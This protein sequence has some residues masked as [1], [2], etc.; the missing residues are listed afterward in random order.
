MGTT[1]LIRLGN[2]FAKR[3]VWAKCEFVSR[4]GSFKIRGAEHLLDH[5][6]KTTSCRE[7]VLP[8]MGNTALGA[9]TAGRQRG[10]RV[11]SVV[12]PNI[13]RAKEEKLGALGVELVKVSGGGSALIEHAEQLAPQRSA[14]FM[15]PHLDRNWTDGYQEI[16]AEI[17][18]E[19]PQCRSL[20]FPVGGGGLLMGLTGYLAKHANG[21]RLYG[22][23]PYNYPTYASFTHARST[24]IADGLILE[25]P[26]AAVQ[27]RINEM[28]VRIVVVD[29]DA[30]RTGLRGLY[31][32]QG[33]VVEP[34]SAVTVAFI[35]EHEELPEPICAI[36]T[37][38]NITEEDFARLIV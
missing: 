27:E 2:L 28:G 21:A 1:P 6:S 24:T 20:V 37:G 19:L 17:L 31:E 3:E 18:Q 8:S 38:R 4:S 16:A 9:A 29:E 32:K 23:E 5:L 25:K 15:H 26:H 11:T 10:F 7:L 22:V 33:L 35:Q 14:Y 30:I 12:P 13:S 34:S 36:L